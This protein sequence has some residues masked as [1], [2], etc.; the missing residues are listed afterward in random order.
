LNKQDEAV[1]NLQQE[2]SLKPGAVS[3]KPGFK[4]VGLLVLMVSG[5]AYVG[6][7]PLFAALNSANRGAQMARMGATAEISPEDVR[8]LEKLY[9]LKRDREALVFAQELCAR[10]S[11]DGL[12]VKDRHLTWILGAKVAQRLDDRKNCLEFC[13][14]IYDGRKGDN[15]KYREALD[16]SYAWACGVDL[17]YELLA[18]KARLFDMSFQGKNYKSL[19]LL[20]REM[21]DMVAALPEDSYLKQKVRLFQALSLMQGTTQEKQTSL[22]V[23][24]LH[25]LERDLLALQEV[26]LAHECA[27]LQLELGGR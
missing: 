16:A 20:A 18:G 1:L 19:P 26:G 27:Q 25:K 11:P 12:D 10:K 9:G 13:R 4:K 15:D 5:V 3:V 8:H 23:E 24:A 7:S 17:D 22:T 21:K 2:P 6:L 14:K